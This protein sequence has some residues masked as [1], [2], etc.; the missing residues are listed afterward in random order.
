MYQVAVKN[1]YFVPGAERRIKSS[2]GQGGRLRGLVITLSDVISV[3]WNDN[4][5]I[6]DFDDDA[7]S[8]ETLFRLFVQYSGSSGAVVDSNRFNYIIRIPGAGIR[9]PNGIKFTPTANVVESVSVFYEG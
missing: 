2:A 9:F 1:E 4:D 6:M 5:R 8:G 7:T 3:A